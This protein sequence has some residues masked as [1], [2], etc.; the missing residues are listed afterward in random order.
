MSDKTPTISLLFF[1]FQDLGSEIYA[2]EERYAFFVYL[3]EKFT[4]GLDQTKSAEVESFLANICSLGYPEVVVPG[5]PRSTIGTV[6]K[7]IICS[8][9]FEPVRFF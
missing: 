6:L 4:R 1:S 2:I 5:G 7:S 8:K 9:G 3:L